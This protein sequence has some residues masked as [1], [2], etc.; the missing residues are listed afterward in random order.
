MPSTP[1]SALRAYRLRAGQQRLLARHFGACRFVWNNCLRVRSEAYRDPELV[2][3]FGRGLSIGLIDLS[4]WLTQL[5]RDDE[6]G[7]TWLSE[8]DSGV[9]SQ[10]LRDQDTAFKNFFAGRG[11]YPRRKNCV[12][13]ASCRF[14]FDHRHAGKVKALNAGDLVLPL[15]GQLPIRWSR[16]PS[17]MPKLVTVSIDPAGRFHVSMAVEEAISEIVAAP[18]LAIGIDVGIKHLVVTSDGE[19]IENPAHLK[20]RLRYLR[21]MSRS[22]S[23]KTKGSNRYRRQQQRIGN[24][25]C[26]IADARRDAQHQLTHKLTRDH[27]T[28]C[29]ETL[30]VK[31]M[32]QNPKLARAIS[33]AA[34]G[35][36]RRQITYK[37]Q[38]RR[39]T[40]QAISTWHPSSQLCSCCGL[41]H[42]ELNLTDR[43]WKCSSCGTEHD[44]D[45]NAAINIRQEGLRLL[46]VGAGSPELM[47]VEGERPPR[48]AAKVAAPK[49]P[50]E[51]RTAVRPS[52][53]PSRQ[54][55]PSR[56]ETWI[57]RV[58]G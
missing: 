10:V 27:Q 56:S 58:E 47:R 28:I 29:T 24:L 57:S 52:S 33:D 17:V 48:S 55:R 15:I 16:R 1:T 11:K 6:A 19:K 46:T 4:R 18:R 22:L 37:S 2:E 31:G 25:H 7:C 41:R 3:M 8:I 43:I 53:L 23:R 26:H 38:W 13:H 32:V 35:E 49:A 51:T 42:T 20:R 36:I 30:N 21:R 40:H 5:K 50:V 9:I 45:I 39:R 44:R 14:V 34:F 12:G 54:V